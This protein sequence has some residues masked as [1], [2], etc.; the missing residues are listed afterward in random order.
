MAT[1][2]RQT[3][4]E[5]QPWTCSHGIRILDLTRLLPGGY[6]TMHL[7]DLGADVIK[8][9]EPR[10]GDLQCATIAPSGFELLNRNK[11]SITI[12]LKQEAGR[13]LLTAA[14]V[15][16]PMCSSRASGRGSWTGSGW[17]TRRSAE[18]QP[19]ISLLLAQRLWPGRPA[20]AGQRA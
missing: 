20:P 14:G 7:A 11:R 19:G 12:D 18:R 13:G 8:V 9:E 4:S 15:L 1:S 2:V 10:V 16:V 5:G 17:A 3:A 6:A